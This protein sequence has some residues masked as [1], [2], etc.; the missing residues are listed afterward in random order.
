MVIDGTA[1]RRRAGGGVAGGRPGRRLWAPVISLRA[2][3]PF[4][5]LL[6]LSAGCGR[7]QGQGASQ[8]EQGIFADMGDPL[9]SATAEQ[10]ATFERG[11]Q[12]GM[13]RFTPEEGL[14][15]DFNVTS[16]T[17]CH[18]KPTI[19][20]AAGRYRNFLLVRAVL[21][22]GS[23][24]NVGV[25]GVQPQFTLKPGGRRPTDPGTNLEATRNPIPFFGVGLLA[26]IPESEILKREDPNDAD[27]DGISGRANYDRGFVGRFGRKAQTVSIEG[28]I[29]GPLFNHLGITT[30][31]LP[32]ALKAML[33]VPSAAP[34][35][36]SL[37]DL[38]FVKPALAQVAAPDT[39][40][41]DDDGVPDPEMS[42][43]DLFDLVSFSMLLAAPR[44]DPP[45]AETEAGSQLFEQIR[46][47]ACH[48]RALQGP[49]GPIPAYSDL[50]LHDMGPDLADGMVFGLAS[51][52]EFRTQPLWG[53]AAV[54]PYLHDGRADTLD[55]A[56]RMHGGE[57][58]ASRDAY[59]ALTSAEQ[60]EVIAFLNS[61]GGSKQRSDGLLPPGAPILPARTVGGPDAPLSASEQQLFSRGRQLF[62]RDIPLAEGLGPNFN[63]DS[64][65]ACHF[66]PVIG[67][68]GPA[69]VDVSR[70]G[71]LE[72]GIF[73]APEGGTIAPRDSTSGNTRPPIDP[74]SNT[75]ETRQPPPLFGLGFLES[76]P[77]ADILA[78]ADC[79][80]PDPSAISGC[81]HILP[82]GQLGRF[83]WKANVPSVEEFARDALSNE[84]G[85]TVPSVFG[86]TFGTLTDSDAVQD[87][88][89]NEDDIDALVFYMK[90]LAPPPGQ[91]KDPEAEA[92]GKILFDQV[93]CT[94][95]HV[96]TF[97]APGGIVAYTDLLLHQ[98]APDG[99]PGIAD[100]SAGPL[101]IRT[102]PLWGLSLTAPYMH[103]GRSFSIDDA[104]DRHDA[105]GA[106][107]RQAYEA[108]T[109]G[110]KSDLLAF[111]GSL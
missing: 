3:C 51:G 12:V 68:S 11:R 70:Q 84:S 44:P 62:D 63:G 88:E 64:C 61:L 38:L 26:E 67:G 56:I 81:A 71:R 79:D 105:E 15:P 59:V 69:D 55:E 52:S 8:A 17:S 89:T 4:V 78:N 66:M 28:F 57:A 97:V 13:H 110:E 104:I 23:S 29:R 2:V 54:A 73:T 75:F 48:V 100:G 7:D 90:H 98:V 30:N 96:T 99:S 24:I 37:A 101:E 34:P 106:Q 6:M 32:D 87:P 103:D 43:Q 14:G 20:G 1:V 58:A 76:I 18:E 94:G 25:N 86:F 49:R 31:P 39:P 60:D 65:R 10:L 19:G 42:D 109:A 80:N 93:G 22:D 82:S 83:G 40:L 91:S 108:L 107:S 36:S 45:T 74:I 50:L 9:P 92:R 35:S 47:T 77:D 46:C 102:P 5:V 27:G 53:V 16:C 85:L 21:S 95:C 33:P 41:T 72:N 111:L